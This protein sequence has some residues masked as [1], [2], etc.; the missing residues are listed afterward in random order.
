MNI[1]N[2]AEELLTSLES[3]SEQV[4]RRVTRY[5]R[6]HKRLLLTIAALIAI[7]FSLL[8]E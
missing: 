3:N 5:I 1:T 7:W 6:S 8:E 4:V 2:K